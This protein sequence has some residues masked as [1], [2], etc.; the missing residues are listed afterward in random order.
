VVISIADNYVGWAAHLSEIERLQNHIA[1]NIEAIKKHPDFNQVFQADLD[2]EKA[3]FDYYL[4]K[5]RDNPIQYVRKLNYY[6][7][8]TDK[9]LYK[10]THPAYIS[11]KE[12]RKV[13][14]LWGRN[15]ATMT[16]EELIV[17]FERE[18][19]ITLEYMASQ[20]HK[21]NPKYGWKFDY[22]KDCSYA[23]NAVLRLRDE[24][25][26]DERNIIAHSVFHR[27]DR[28]G[29]YAKYHYSK[30][31]YEEVG[32]HHSPGDEDFYVKCLEEEKAK[33]VI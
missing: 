17:F 24:S 23:Y 25:N 7:E 30:M 21:K 16:M 9:I 28:E 5:L 1:D 12:I 18:D 22:G 33:E 20:I 19:N 27:Y 6:G 14:E 8:Q 4:Y 31:L 15:H 32:D 3:W 11:K 29:M 26:P 10:L 13:M 2:Y